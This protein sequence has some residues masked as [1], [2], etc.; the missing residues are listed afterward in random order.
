MEWD[1]RKK[2]PYSGYENYDFDIPSCTQRQIVTTVQMVRVE[3][4]WQS[5]RII[6]QCLNNMPAGRL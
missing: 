1:M 3:E 4:M 6:E 5:L 2:R